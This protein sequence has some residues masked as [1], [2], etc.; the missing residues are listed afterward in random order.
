MQ[1]AHGGVYVEKGKALFFGHGLHAWVR[2]DT[3][4]FTVG[5]RVRGAVYAGS[6]PLAPWD[7]RGSFEG[8]FDALV[9]AFK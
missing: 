7:E 9:C 2:W 3:L 4:A 8:S 5:A 1:P 6:D